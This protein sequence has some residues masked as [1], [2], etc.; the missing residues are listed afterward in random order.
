MMRGAPQ[1]TQTRGRGLSTGPV[2]TQA[3]LAGFNLY[4]PRP[5]EPAE[6]RLVLATVSG[7]TSTRL[8]GSPPGTPPP[9]DKV[10]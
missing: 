8:A 1:R 5:V 7:R 6:R 2:Y 3:L 4:V 10:G 9:G